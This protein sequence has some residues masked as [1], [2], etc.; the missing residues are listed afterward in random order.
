MD[1][2]LPYDLQPVSS[3]AIDD[4]DL[5]FFQKTYLPA[6]VASSTLEENERPVE[7]QLASLRLTTVEPVPRPTVLGILTLAYE[8]QDFLPGAYCQFLR[9]DGEE[10]SDPIL[11]EKKIDGSLLEILESLDRILN[12]NITSPIDIHSENKEVIHPYYPL[13]ALQQIVRNAIMH[14]T[15]EATNAPVRIYWFADRIEVLSPGGPYGQVTVDNFGQPG[16]TDY[17]NPYLAEVMKNLG[18]VQRFG[19]GLETAKKQLLKNGNPVPEFIV[20]NAHILVVIR[21]RP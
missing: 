18:Y 9:I 20:N 17:R 4:L 2:D 7:Q 15:Y 10:L 11:D 8:P 21:R 19:I 16:I 12:L 14:R 1:K 5:A 3:A 13:S 6:S